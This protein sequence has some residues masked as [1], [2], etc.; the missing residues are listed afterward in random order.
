MSRLQYN[1][2]L[3]HLD[4]DLSAGATAITFDVP[5][6]HSGG[7]NVPTLSGGDYFALTILDANAVPREIVYVTAYTAGATTATITRGQEGT[8]GVTHSAGVIVLHAPTVYD[9]NPLTNPAWAAKGDLLVGS[10]NDTAIIKSVGADATVLTA[11]AAAAGGMKWAAPSS[12]TLDINNPLSSAANIT[13]LSG[14]WGINAGVLRQS[15]GGAFA[16]AYHNVPWSGPSGLIAVQ[17]EVAWISGS[18]TRRFGI[19]WRNRAAGN[20]NMDFYIESG[21]GVNWTPRLERGGSALLY[22]GSAV[23]VTPGAW[24]TM[25]LI[26]TG[27]TA[28]MYF[29][30]T[31][32][33]RGIQ[34][35]NQPAVYTY[36]YIG[37]YCNTSVVDFRNLKGWRG[38]SVPS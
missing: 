13:T 30:G 27:M 28:D 21:D 16:E 35:A 14:T 10:A 37:L 17:C 32:V 4:A 31:L 36:P 23:A 1:G 18:S 11:D 15:N 33:G 7:T 8:S 6:T 12:W 5:L 24:N 19:E 9:Y 20:E 34:V 3:A 2:V 22:T 38:L 26:A 29:N 25:L